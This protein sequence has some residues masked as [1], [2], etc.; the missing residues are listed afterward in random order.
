MTSAWLLDGAAL[1]DAT[2]AVILCAECPCGETAPPCCPDGDV[3]PAVYVWA[4]SSSAA[5]DTPP[6]YHGC[7]SLDCPGLVSEGSLNYRDYGSFS[8]GSFAW[9]LGSFTTVGK[10][11]CANVTIRGTCGTTFGGT[12]DFDFGLGYLGQQTFVN[13]NPTPT[14]CVLTL[15]CDAY[16]HSAGPTNVNYYL[17]TKDPATGILAPDVSVVPTTVT[18]GVTL[19]SGLMCSPSLYSCALIFSPNSPDFGSFGCYQW[20][21]YLTD[22]TS[23]TV[24]H[25]IV[26]FY[27]DDISPWSFGAPVAGW[28][29]LAYIAPAT[30]ERVYAAVPFPGSGNMLDD[31]PACGA[32]TNTTP[33][34]SITE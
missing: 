30:V 8:G 17:T 31:W 14:R 23:G 34:W 1:V 7:L 33:M 25:G 15:G 6:N 28:V 21:G 3:L 22:C 4:Y 27:T 13:D 5:I 24:C 32:C 9:N 12:I 19:M 16:G 20:S 29:I 18:F 26:M 2:G 10:I 11:G